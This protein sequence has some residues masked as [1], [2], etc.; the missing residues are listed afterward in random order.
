MFRLNVQLPCICEQLETWLKY[1]FQKQS[2]KR[3]ILII[4]QKSMFYI[5]SW[6]SKGEQNRLGLKF[7]R[8]STTI[9]RETAHVKKHIQRERTMRS[10][11]Q[12]K[13]NGRKIKKGKGRMSSWF[14][15]FL[16]ASGCLRGLSLVKS[17]LNY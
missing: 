1:I 16:L 14:M 3:N 13:R 11:K 10:S 2:V 6:Y 15:T 17:S 5:L 7:V 9:L 8:F 4:G 12:S